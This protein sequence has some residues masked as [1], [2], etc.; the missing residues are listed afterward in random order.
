[1]VPVANAE[2]HVE[3]YLLTDA[4]VLDSARQYITKSVLQCL[5]SGPIALPLPLFGCTKQFTGP[6]L[7]N[8]PCN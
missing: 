5:C 3:V 8:A 7:L 2:G 6:L 4:F 1:M